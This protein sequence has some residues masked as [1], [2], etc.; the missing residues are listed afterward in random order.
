MLLDK[1]GISRVFFL[2]M[3]QLLLYCMNIMLGVN[4]EN[5]NYINIYSIIGG[6]AGYANL[7]G[8]HRAGDRPT[9]EFFHPE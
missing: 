3:D 6:I 2:L 5:T 4:D 8:C 9:L 7:A 1:R